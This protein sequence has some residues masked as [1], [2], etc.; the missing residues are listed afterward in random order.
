[1]AQWRAATAALAEQRRRELRE[2]TDEL[3]LAAADAV[4][5]LASPATLTPERRNGSG[6]VEQQAILHRRRSR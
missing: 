6:L 5:A 3:G 2:L 1:M 4:L